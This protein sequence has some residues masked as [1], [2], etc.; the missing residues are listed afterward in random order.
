MKI[1]KDTDYFAMLSKMIACTHDAARMLLD[2]G[3]SVSA[4]AARVGVSDAN[5]FC[6]IFKSVMGVSPSEYRLKQSAAVEKGQN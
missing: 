3:E 2:S 1:K 4:I 5:Y 6:R